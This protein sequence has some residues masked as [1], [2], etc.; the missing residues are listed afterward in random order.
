M[1][2]E[3]ASEDEGGESACYAHLACPQCGSILDGSGHST[4]CQ[5]QQPDMDIAA[6]LAGTP[7][8]SI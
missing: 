3:L 5:W 4:K 7:E 6:T 1:A 8:S 2:D